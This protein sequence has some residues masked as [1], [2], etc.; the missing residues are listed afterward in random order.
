MP[1]DISRGYFVEAE[2]K[3]IAL[4]FYQPKQRYI[5]L[6]YD[7]SIDWSGI[8]PVSVVP[9]IH[10]SELYFR[11]FNS[12]KL[13]SIHVNFSCFLSFFRILIRDLINCFKS[14]SSELNMELSL[15]DCFVCG[16]PI[17]NFHEEISSILNLGLLETINKKQRFCEKPVSQLYFSFIVHW[18][19]NHTLAHYCNTFSMVFKTSI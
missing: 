10:S 17:L 5:P 16:L 11:N 3:L 8:P 14:L 2:G 6:L 1:Y 19:Q 12:C 15:I 18:W 13:Q 4:Q 9:Y 7:L